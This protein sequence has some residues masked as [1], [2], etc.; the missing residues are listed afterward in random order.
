MVVLI[1]QA[2]I[3]QFSSPYNT[4]QETPAGLGVPTP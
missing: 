2:S 1:F 3:L 4:S